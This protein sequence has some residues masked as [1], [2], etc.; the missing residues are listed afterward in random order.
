MELA[1]TW[2]N[3]HNLI[4]EL[5]TDVVPAEFVEMA[6]FLSATSLKY[7]LTVNPII[8][9]SHI[10]HFWHSAEVKKVKG[11]LCVRAI[12][13]ECQVTVSESII[14]DTQVFDDEDGVTGVD[15]DELFEGLEEIGYEKKD[16]GLKF[17][18]GLFP[19]NFKFLA[20]TL[21]HCLSNKTTG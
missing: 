21:L 6:T 11:E 14:R 20:H 2:A 19:T 13:D 5:D 12:V 18:K 16:N 7:A 8:Y 4:A 15:R 1:R 9:A 10:R 3:N 17:Q